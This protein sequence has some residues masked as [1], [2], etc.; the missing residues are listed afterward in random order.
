MRD[1]RQKEVK[2]RGGGVRV[3]QGGETLRT[4]DDKIR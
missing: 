3:K 1:D 4:K 2:R